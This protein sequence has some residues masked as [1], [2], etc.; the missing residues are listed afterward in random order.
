MVEN[1]FLILKF[2]K[3]ERVPAGH[4]LTKKSVPDSETVHRVR[5]HAI[6]QGLFLC[7]CVYGNRELGGVFGRLGV[8]CP[9]PPIH[10][11]IVTRLTCFRVS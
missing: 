5:G 4:A 7:M 10:N 11:D 8:G 6:N 1:N 2:S 3:H 9:C